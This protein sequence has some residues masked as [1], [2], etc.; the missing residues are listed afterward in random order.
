MGWIFSTEIVNKKRQVELDV[1]KGIAIVFMIWV[2]VKEYYLG[3]KF[4]GC[5]YDEVCEFFGSPPTAPVFMIALGIGVHFARKNAPKDLAVRGIKIFVLSY[6]LNFIR[7]TVPLYIQ[8]RMD[9]DRDVYEESL[10]S[11][12][13]VDILQFAGLAF[14]FLALIKKLQMNYKMLFVV[15]CVLATGNMLLSGISFTNPAANI[16]FGL[17]WETYDYSWF[18]CLPWITYPMVGYVFGGYLI[19]CKDKK[20]FY[21]NI[22]VVCG[23]LS[24]PLW[25]YSYI[26]NVRFGAFGNLWQDEYYGHDIMG[27]L[28]L[29]TFALFWMSLVYFVVPYIPSL[30]VRMLTRWSKN[31]NR[32]FCISYVYLGWGLLVLKGSDYTPAF[33]SVLAVI[34]FILTDLT[35]FIYEKILL[36]IR[37]S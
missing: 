1:A 3:A 26:H 19:R 30:F 12:V 31:T 2:H 7:D 6:I 22:C 24:V 23:A 8:Y 29:V 9:G 11:L 15:W 25:L 37:K 14:L 16:I 5:A 32:L 34:F 10:Y 33:V 17:I 13:G 4:E 21:R 36:R 28:V 35:C 18:P 27:N 20:V